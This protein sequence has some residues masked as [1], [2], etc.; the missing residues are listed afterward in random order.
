MAPHNELRPRK[1]TELIEEALRA[2]EV[3]TGYRLLEGASHSDSGVFI[4]RRQDGPSA[5]GA[6]GYQPMDPSR[7]NR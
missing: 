7:R 2:L 4:T 5:T 3:S 6:R 1:T